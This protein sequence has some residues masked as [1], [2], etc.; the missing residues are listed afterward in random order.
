MGKNL[1]K[2]NKK[3]NTS[4][5]NVKPK[6]TVINSRKE[7]RKQERILKKQNKLHFYEKKY[8]REKLKEIGSREIEENGIGNEKLKKPLSDDTLKIKNRE[9]K[10]SEQKLKNARRKKELQRANAEE[11][12][13]IKR[14]EK[15]LKLNKRKGKDKETRLPSSFSAEGLDYILDVCDPSKIE[16]LEMSESEDDDS[17]GEQNYDSDDLDEESQNDSS[18]TLKQS[19]LYDINLNTGEDEELNSE[20]SDDIEMDPDISGDENIN[21]NLTE[22]ESDNMQDESDQGESG[23]KPTTVSNLNDKETNYWEDI[24]GRTRD[25]EGNVID[26]QSDAKSDQNQASRTLS[27]K[28]IPPA[29]RA[30]MEAGNE[31]LIK[32]KKQIKG[33]LNRL[34]ESNMHSICR[35][36][37]DLYSCNSRNDMNECL[38][39]IISASILE[40]S[41]TSPTPER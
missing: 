12:K 23:D 10:E 7:K 5:S 15:Q 17:S 37:E 34:A 40:S 4:Q 31:K 11:E 3:G 2:S 9:K 25:A 21:S 8:H 20:I 19:E 6:F 14:L 22:N 1:L 33:L 29:M 24:Y 26:L 13:N 39:E 41:G 32:L 18:S 30:K 28:Y 27:N 35:Q 38:S 16:N 36:L